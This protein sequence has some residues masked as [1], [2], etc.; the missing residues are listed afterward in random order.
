MTSYISH[1]TLDSHDAYAQ[2]VW[3]G[4]VLGYGENPDDPNEPGHEECPIFSADQQHQILFIEVPDAKP[5]EP[6]TGFVAP[7]VGRR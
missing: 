1:T 6:G 5:D 2:S 4:A 3:W 7:A